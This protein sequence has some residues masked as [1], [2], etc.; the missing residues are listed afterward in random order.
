M[1]KLLFASLL[2]SYSI[3]VISLAHEFYIPELSPPYEGPP[4]DFASIYA[5][6]WL[7]RDKTTFGTLAKYSDVIGIGN[8]VTQDL[9]KLVIQVETALVGCTN[10]QT[11]IIQVGNHDDLERELEEY[12][13]SKEFFATGLPTNDSRIVF[14]IYYHSFYPTVKPCKYWI[15]FYKISC[16][17]KL[18]YFY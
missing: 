6:N 17:H 3:C 7:I 5:N 18:F 14:N 11:L 13:Y 2:I 8:V 12:G 16:L 4:D 15:C 9:L 1:K 10:G